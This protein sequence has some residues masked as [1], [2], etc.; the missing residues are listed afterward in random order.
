MRSS[1]LDFAKC[2]KVSNALSVWRL[3]H[4]QK[5]VRMKHH[6]ISNMR[7]VAHSSC[8]CNAA[9]RTRVE[10]SSSS[11]QMLSMARGSLLSGVFYFL[12]LKRAGL[13]SSVSPWLAR[14]ISLP[15]ICRKIAA[16]ILTTKIITP[17]IAAAIITV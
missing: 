14:I 7:T 9:Q 10:K 3:I 5:M 2:P 8:H 12:D 4:S 15:R 1:M 17:A 13:P 6:G 11:L 16:K